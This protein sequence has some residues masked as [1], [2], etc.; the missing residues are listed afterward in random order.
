M[1]DRQLN[2]GCLD[3]IPQS[4]QFRDCPNLWVNRKSAVKPVL[5][6]THSGPV[7]QIRYGS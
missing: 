3:V 1:G 7:S 5:I 2:I 4:Q 6:Y